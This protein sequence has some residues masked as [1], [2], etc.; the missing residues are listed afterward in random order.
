MDIEVEAKFRKNHLSLLEAASFA[1]IDVNMK[2]KE[3]KVAITKHLTHAQTGLPTSW[4]NYRV[5]VM[6]TKGATPQDFTDKV[7]AK[8]KEAD[9]VR[10]HEYIQSFETAYREQLSLL[11]GMTLA[12]L[13][14]LKGSNQI[15]L[16]VIVSDW[17]NV[18]HLEDRLQSEFK[19]TFPG[20]TATKGA[21]FWKGRHV[22][23]IR[24]EYVEC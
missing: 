21:G 20:R 11:S 10:D 17:H 24:D 3:I 13:R 2:A 8:I 12:C 16:V 7:L 9:S 15:V 19:D 1:S 18:S 5:Y 23:I 4:K 14:K 6:Y 22:A